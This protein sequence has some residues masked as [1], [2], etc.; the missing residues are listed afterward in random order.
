MI[1]TKPTAK[2]GPRHH[3][4]QM[5]LKAFEFAQVEEG[6]QVELARG[7][8]VVSEVANYF[9]A[10][11]VMAILECLWAYKINQKDKIHAILG[12]MDCKLLIPDWDSERHPDIAVYLKPPTGPKNRTMWRRWLPEL[13]IEVVSEGSRDRDYTEKRDEYWTLG[14]KEFWIVDAKLEQVLLLRRGR[15]HWGEKTLGSND[16][17]ETKLLPGFKLAC[18]LI[19]DAAKDHEE[20]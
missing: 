5:S 7:Y 17:C 6:Y 1:F 16:V 20:S 2:I 11:Q 12:N 18:S 19:F 4:R 10:M 8:I 15:S 9:H 3:G 14:I 13:I